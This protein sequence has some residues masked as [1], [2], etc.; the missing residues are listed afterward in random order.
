MSQQFAS[1]TAVL[2]PTTGVNLLDCIWTYNVFYFYLVIIHWTYEEQY[3]PEKSIAQTAKTKVP[4]TVKFKTL[5]V[6]Q[7]LAL[8]EEL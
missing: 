6:S 3:L 7:W 1:L 4:I 2:D 5:L 8:A